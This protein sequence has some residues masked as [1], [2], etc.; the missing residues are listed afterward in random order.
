LAFGPAL[1]DPPGFYRSDEE[2][3]PAS[4]RNNWGRLLPVGLWG[5]ETGSPL[6]DAPWGRSFLSPRY[7]RCDAVGQPVSL[8]CGQSNAHKRASRSRFEPRFGLSV[9]HGPASRHSGGRFL[10]LTDGEVSRV[11]KGADCKSAAV[12]LRRFESF[13]PHQPSLAKREKAAAPKP[14]G[15]RRAAARELRLGKPTSPSPQNRPNDR[16]IPSLA[17]RG[18]AATPKPKGRRQAVAASYR[19][20]SVHF[21]KPLTFARHEIHDLARPVYLN[22]SILTGDVSGLH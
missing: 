17:K 19:S 15:R 7:S 4:G 9:I 6:S 22:P 1:Q 20:A 14:K 16:L 5:L 12:W 2:T 8:S 13:L 11:A 3:A 21:Q 18:K 10:M